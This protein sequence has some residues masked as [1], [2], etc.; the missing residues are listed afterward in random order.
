MVAI[1]WQNIMFLNLLTAT[2]QRQFCLFFST[3]KD[4]PFR[5]SLELCMAQV[6]SPW[7]K[8]RRL[9]RLKQSIAIPVVPCCV[10][11]S[12]AL[13]CVALLWE[14]WVLISPELLLPSRVTEDHLSP[15][16]FPPVTKHAILNKMFTLPLSPETGRFKNCWI[17][18]ISTYR[19]TQEDFSSRGWCITDFKEST[20]VE[21]W[22]GWCSN[23]FYSALE[24][25]KWQQKD[26][27]G[28]QFG[29]FYI[30]SHSFFYKRPY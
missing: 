5:R 30:H 23:S 19:L 15:S 6:Q 16:H 1:H 14:R 25:A 22:R 2:K 29:F 26:G 27:S 4:F 7:W 28:D 21:S 11:H 3:G 20:D 10:C 13:L 9:Q 18:Y 17:M 8:I 24:I 12:C